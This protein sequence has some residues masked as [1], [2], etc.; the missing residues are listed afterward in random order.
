MNVNELNV[1]ARAVAYDSKVNIVNGDPKIDGRTISLPLAKAVN[2]PPR[3]LHGYLDHEAAHCMFTDFEQQIAKG[4]E[5]DVWNLIED[6]R[7]EWMQM[8]RLPGARSNLNATASHVFKSTPAEDVERASDEALFLS[9]LNR[10]SRREI[11]GQDVCLDGLVNAVDNG[12]YGA[13]F[14]QSAQIICRSQDPDRH[15]SLVLAREII[16]LMR[17]AKSQPENEQQ[18]GKPG[19][20]SAG[21]PEGKSSGEPGGNPEGQPEGE[22]QKAQGDGDPK[23]GEPEPGK[24]QGSSE[25]AGLSDGDRER[26][27]LS[28]S[29]AIA[30]EMGA[31]ASTPLKAPLVAAPGSTAYAYNPA[32]VSQVERC[33]KRMLIAKDDLRAPRHSLTGRLDRKK[34][35]KA[36]IPG[37]V[38]IFRKKRR[39][40]QQT[41]SA[42]VLVILD[43][44]SSM[45]RNGRAQTAAACAHAIA[46]AV[47]RY[48]NARS[49]VLGFGV[50]THQASAGLCVLKDWHESRVK[51]PVIANGGA[52]PTAEAAEF[53][54][55]M[56]ATEKDTKQVVLFVTDGRPGNPQKT[57]GA[58]QALLDRGVRVG[59]CY[60][61][62]DSIAAM[63]GHF[64]RA[65]E[66][67]ELP[68]RLS[69]LFA[70]CV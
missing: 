22:P 70:Q 52:T 31:K 2:L 28:V 65:G 69:R 40:Q 56:L 10:H 50:K 63:P 38:N 23:P 61:G 32:L 26:M 60:I 49:A 11:L 57:T 1:I 16:E 42:R 62:E 34:L 54:R 12:V 24:A 51:I 20:D 44:S 21:K 36:A 19:G 30:K 9:R 37:Q 48:P 3:V 58:M 47:T 43:C 45:A 7:I 14:N 35:Y 33:I 67:S 46:A 64:V 55:V 13:I 66:I 15:I 4:L 8:K 29:E 53:A 17:K 6:I 68:N 25:P 18:K 27:K 59:T 5:H 41:E 39:K